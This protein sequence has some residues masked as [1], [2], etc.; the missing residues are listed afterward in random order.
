MYS[1]SS[2]GDRAFS[3][4]VPTLWIALPDDIKART[5]LSVFKTKIKALLFKKTYALM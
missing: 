1:L 5:S 4:I 2:Y 3:S